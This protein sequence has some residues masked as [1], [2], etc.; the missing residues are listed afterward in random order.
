M[1]ATPGGICRGSRTVTL[2]SHICASRKDWPPINSSMRMSGEW[3]LPD[4]GSDA[5]MVDPVIA[6]M[7]SYRERRGISVTGTLGSGKDGYVWR[8]CRHTA[9]KVHGRVESY[10]AERNAYIRFQTLEIEEVSGFAIPVLWDFDDELFAIEMGIVAPPYIVDFASAHLDST[11]E[12]IEDEG[13]TLHDMI[14]QRFDARADEVIGL[15]EDLIA[16]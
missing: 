9:L 5:I 7:Q 14:R 12:F 6:R 2:P 11:P 16:S 10:R 8:T 4:K 15:Y 3:P 1:V 13:H